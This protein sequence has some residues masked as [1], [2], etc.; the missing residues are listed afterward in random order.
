M[1]EGTMASEPMISGLVG[2]FLGTFTTGM[3]IRVGVLLL[4]AVVLLVG[5]IL[6]NKL[7]TKKAAAPEIAMPKES[8]AQET[9]VPEE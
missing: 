4:A 3:W 6:I 1:L 8:V 7:R 2:T 5:Y 9:A